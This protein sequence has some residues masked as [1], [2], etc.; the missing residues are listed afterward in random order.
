MYF[1]NKR[2]ELILGQQ[3]SLQQSEEKILWKQKAY[4]KTWKIKLFFLDTF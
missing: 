2:F 1:K 3:K 4:S